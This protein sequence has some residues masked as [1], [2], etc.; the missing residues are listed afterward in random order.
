MNIDTSNN[1]HHIMLMAN[2]TVVIHLRPR[3]YSPVQVIS[4]S[5]CGI[6]QVIQENILFIFSI[7]I[8]RKKKKKKTQKNDI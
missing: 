5:I 2:N 3:T 4:V 1:I 8:E 7:K 6:L